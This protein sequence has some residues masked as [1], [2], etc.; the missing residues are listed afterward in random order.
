MEGISLSREIR[1]YE[2][3][4]K[5]NYR[6]LDQEVTDS[7]PEQII[8]QLRQV[9]NQQLSLLNDLISELEE[10]MPPSPSIRLAHHIIQQEETLFLLARKY[11]T[12]VAN[13]LRVNPDIKDPDEIQAGM[14]VN[15][16]ILL[17]QK[18]ACYFEYTVKSGDTLFGLAQ[19]FSTTVNELVY[20]NSISDADLIYPGRILIIPGSGDE[21]KS[22]E[23][24]EGDVALS[25]EDNNEGRLYF[26]TLARNNENSFDRIIE[27]S[28]FAANTKFRLER[29]LDDFSIQIPSDIN[30][31][32]NIVIG[33]VG[34]DIEKLNLKN[35]VI[36]TV[37]NGKFSGYHLITVPKEEFSFG[38]SYS[39]DFVTSDDKSLYQDR[40]NISF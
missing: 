15:L 13:I 8:R 39:I 32:E 14:V 20:Y 26:S 25:N 1:S 36:R 38:G 9:Q 27:E 7:D 10:S 17:P 34:Y 29:I 40:I 16:P 22:K 2:R 18:P 28:L 11:N 37:I 6:R 31:E 23:E 4:L 30:F 19:R 5:K 3:S 21:K 35:G 12:T 24:Y 33:A